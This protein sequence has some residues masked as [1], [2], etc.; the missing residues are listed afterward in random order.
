MAA[1]LT[2]TLWD[3]RDIVK[4]IEEAEAAWLVEQP[5]HDEQ[6]YNKA[7]RQSHDCSSSDTTPENFLFGVRHFASPWREA[8]YHNPKSNC[9]SAQL[10]ALLQF[11]FPAGLKG[12]GPGL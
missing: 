10:A 8:L 6:R 9:T 3:V 2:E 12:V 11:R 5:D 1:R 7:A 4:L